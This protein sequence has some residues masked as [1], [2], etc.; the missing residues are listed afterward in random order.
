MGLILFKIIKTKNAWNI[1]PWSIEESKLLFFTSFRMTLVSLSKVLFTGFAF[2]VLLFVSE[3]VF[4]KMM[5]SV[6][7]VSF[8]V[9]YGKNTTVL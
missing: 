2:I 8:V 4:V 3:T 7:V 9:F 5:T 1:Y 6:I